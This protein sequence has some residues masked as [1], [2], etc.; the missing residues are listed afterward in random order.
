[1]QDHWLLW[2][3]LYVGAILNLAIMMN[4]L[5]GIVQNFSRVQEGAAIADANEKIDV[6]KEIEQLKCSLNWMLYRKI[7]QVYERNKMDMEET[8]WAERFEMLEENWFT[9]I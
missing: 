5:I 8:G 2:F 9:I 4:L 1:M 7:F 3:L 6:M